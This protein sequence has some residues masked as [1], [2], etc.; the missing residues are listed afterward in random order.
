MFK[1]KITTISFEGSEIRFLSVRGD[2]VADWKTR[3][4]PQD[5]MSQGLIHKP[6]IVSNIVKTTLKE[7]KASRRNVISAVSGSRSVHRIMH[8]PAIPEKLLEE[9]IQRKARQEFAIPIED[10]DLSWRIIARE[11]DQITLY[12]LAV[13]K[14][15][16]DQQVAALREAKIKPRILDIKPLALTRTANQATAIIVNLE[17]HAM[18]VTVQVNYIPMLVRTIP[19]E[20]GNL[21][22]EAKIDLLG[23]ELARTVKYYNESNKTNRLPENTPVFV[24]GA[25][26]S[27]GTIE[28]RLEE[29][30]SLLQRLQNRTP[31][32]LK[33]PATDLVLPEKFPL[34]RYAVNIGLAAKNVR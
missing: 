34:L 3:E 31:Y 4:V 14:I 8:I 18:G 30:E 28:S 9:T 19:L 12:V 7:L 5:A 32:P 26:F 10:T 25:L 20:S 17:D 27:T 13:P 33:P 11:G 16:I 24:S 2:Q 6:V 1:K 21:T 22:G 23:Q 15:L 29:T